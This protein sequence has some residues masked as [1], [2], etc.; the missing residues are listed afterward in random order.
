MKNTKKQRR[1]GGANRSVKPVLRRRNLLE[2]LRLE[3]LESRQ[4]L[5]LLGVSPERPLIAYGVNTGLDPAPQL[6][7][8]ADPLSGPGVFAYQANGT[9]ISVTF[10]NPLGPGTTQVG[11]GGGLLRDIRYSLKINSDGSLAGG[12]L[13]DDLTISGTVTDPYTGTAYAGV[14]LTGEILNYGSQNGAGTV[15]SPDRFDFLFTPTGGALVTTPGTTF[16]AGKS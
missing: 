4:L 13:G 3:A 6:T 16:F 14:L 15:A 10:E 8:T 12:V 2:G 7:Y 9:P 11:V 1:T 5:T